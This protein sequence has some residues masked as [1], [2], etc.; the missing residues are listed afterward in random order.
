MFMRFREITDSGSEQASAPQSLDYS[1]GD[2]NA[3]Q[4]SLGE[5]ACTAMVA[6]GGLD[7][8]EPSPTRVLRSSKA[9]KDDAGP[10]A[11]GAI[12][13]LSSPTPLMV[14]EGIVGKDNFGVVYSPQKFLFTY[15]PA[16]SIHAKKVDKVLE[17]AVADF[18]KVPECFAHRFKATVGPD[19]EGFIPTVVGG[20]SAKYKNKNIPVVANDDYK[21]EEE[22]EKPDRSEKR[23]RKKTV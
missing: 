11:A 20:I 23:K 2:A 18:N 17:K 1:Q 6:L 15:N 7:L 16:S 3:S 10:P 22:H 4:N 8:V 19:Y 13:D 14:V 5:E 21:D 12:V 9:L